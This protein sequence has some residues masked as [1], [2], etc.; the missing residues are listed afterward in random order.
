V[1]WVAGGC[2]DDDMKLVKWMSP[3]LIPCVKHTH[4]YSVD[5]GF[6]GISPSIDGHRGSSGI[7]RRILWA[8]GIPIFCWG[9]FTIQG[10]AGFRWPIHSMMLEEW[11]EWGTVAYL[12]TH[13]CFLTVFSAQFPLEMIV[14]L[15]S[16]T[17]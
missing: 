4:H 8:S 17:Q 11:M 15:D 9:F 10:D 7:I 5:L 3:E 14:V 13:P 16:Y 12:Q 6:G 1:R 2:W